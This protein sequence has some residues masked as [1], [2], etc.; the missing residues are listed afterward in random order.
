MPK[1]DPP[2]YLNSPN[3]DNEVIVFGKSQEQEAED[4]RNGVARLGG[5]WRQ[6]N[7]ARAYLRAARVLITDA[8]TK[9]DL[10]QLALPIFYLQRHALELLLKSL[11]GLLYDVARMRFDLCQSLKNR[12]NLPSNSAVERLTKSH[13][14]RALNDDL[15]KS[16]ARLQI[17]GYP[18]ELQNLI[19]EIEKYEIN[20]TWSRYPN[21]GVA[22]TNAHLAI[23]VALPLVELHKRVEKVI[24]DVAFDI[25]TGGET[26]EAFIYYEWNSLMQSL[27][28]EG[29]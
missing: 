19:N 15:K 3:H 18:S 8:Q 14:L 12:N 27:E 13:S 25:D 4:F 26:F 1:V 6:P 22:G 7:Y 24:R 21:S 5:R 2:I 20:P 23:E 17:A 11:L 29:G 9:N 10:D 16:S 28:H